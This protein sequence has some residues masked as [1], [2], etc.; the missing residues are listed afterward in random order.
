MSALQDTSSASGD[1]QENAGPVDGKAQLE[2]IEKEILELKNN[3]GLIKTNDPADDTAHQVLPCH[4]LQGHLKGRLHHCA[5]NLQSNL[6]QGP[7]RLPHDCTN[8][9]LQ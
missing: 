6:W 9:L 1:A 5:D 2:A 3:L 8:P 4:V 7:T